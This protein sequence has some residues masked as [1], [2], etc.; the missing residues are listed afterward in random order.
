[1]VAHPDHSR[2][3]QINT[4]HKEGS[5]DFRR[6]FLHPTHPP[7][8]IQPSRH[9]NSSF[10]LTLH[11]TGT[12][13]ITDGPVILPSRSPPS[14][15]RT[16]SSTG[17]LGSKKIAWARIE[18]ESEVRMMDHQSQGVRASLNPR[19]LLMEST[20]KGAKLCYF[21]HSSKGRRTVR[22]LR[23][24][25]YPSKQNNPPPDRREPWVLSMA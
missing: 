6:I 14:P 21:W 4:C 22:R 3:S 18:R 19:F 13:R 23:Q 7:K 25:H 12:R 1:M 8:K 9:R 17:K 16:H 10:G 2:R 24:N 15:V 11:L 5:G 20:T